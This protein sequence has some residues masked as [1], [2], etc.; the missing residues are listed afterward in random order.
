MYIFFVER[1]CKQGIP[2]ILV[3]YF[4]CTILFIINTKGPWNLIILLLI[5]LHLHEISSAKD[6]RHIHDIPYGKN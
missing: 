5:Y 1:Q 2:D 4:S 6:E 3:S